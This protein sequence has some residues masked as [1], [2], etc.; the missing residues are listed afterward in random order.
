MA[1]A[2]QREPAFRSVEE[3]PSDDPAR[4]GVENDREIEKADH[5][6]NEGY[7][8]NPKFVRPL[9][10]KV[11]TKSG[12]LQGMVERVAIW[13]SPDPSADGDRI[14]GDSLPRVEELT[15]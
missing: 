11:S 15:R 7:V 12:R 2:R 14:H 13:P 4:P 10:D 1:R 6:R 5:R 8:A 9:G 3:C